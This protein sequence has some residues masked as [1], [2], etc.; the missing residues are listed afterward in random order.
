VGVWLALAVL[1]ALRVYGQADGSP[2]WAGPFTTGG[3]ILSSPAV[4]PDG[5]IYFGTQDKKLYAINPNGSLKWTFTA[6]D[7]ID[8]TPAIGADGTIY[9]GCWDGN[10]YAVTPQGTEKWRY[11]TGVG[12]YIYS[13]PALGVDGTVY[14]GAG[15]GNFYALRADGALKWTYPAG[16][17]I[18]SSPAIGATGLIYYG[19]WDGVVY[20]LRDET[21]FASEAWRYTTNGPVLSSPGLGRDG[22]V[23][24]GSN[25]GR[26]Y[27][28]EGETG[29][30]R[31]DFTANGTVESSPT[32]GPDGAV[33]FGG[34]T[35]HLHAVNTADGS[36]RWRY[37]TTDPIVSTPAVRAD[38]TVIF[39]GNDSTIY[40]LQPNG[41]GLKWSVKAGDWVDASPVVTPEGYVY[42]GSYDRKLYAFN[43]AGVPLSVFSEWP[44][45][46]RDAPRRA[47]VVPVPVGGQLVNLSTRALAGPGL[48]L[49][50]GFV[51]V[52]SA[53]KSFLIRG[54][55]PALADYGISQ[56]LA[57]PALELHTRMEN[58]DTILGLNDNWSSAA[59]AE[60]VGLAFARTG[61]FP[62][63]PGALDSALLMTLSPRGYTAIVN[64][65]TSS[66][67]IALVEVYDA[68][69]DNTTA[70]LVNLST[71]GQVGVGEGALTAGLVIRGTAPLQVLIRAVGPTLGSVFGVPNTLE[72]PSL[73]LYSGQT[74]IAS[75]TGWSSTRTPADLRGASM[76]SGA[77]PL[78]ENSQDSALLTTLDP[79]GY[80]MSVTGVG[81]TT[82]EVILEVYV[83]P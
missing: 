18:D 22:T 35:G 41:T 16:D 15:D 61:A 70:R 9:F 83:V 82:G 32:V 59:N 42:V 10:L 20:A 47:R 12:N 40:A 54:I 52:G 33:Y 17:W 7:W 46:R 39:G 73:T 28:L 25:D 65:V 72:R 51:V 45:F 21:S 36:L 26:V 30:L 71:R 57:N 50:P 1:G 74:P 34:G 14:F 68:D 60:Q 49:I 11:S 77:F 75:N 55:G 24:I 66:S 5:T 69:A 37:P 4:A 48:N 53:A 8:S 67:G 43:G 81:D 79:G 13:S 76:A 62:L 78:L 44:A 2:R 64:S 56:P 63:Q 29:V 6:G 58:Q 3:Y 31:W 38:G 80:T 23:Y 19:S 27:A